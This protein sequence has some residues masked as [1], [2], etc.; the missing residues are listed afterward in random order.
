MPYEA[1]G[2][3]ADETKK[4]SP[5]SKRLCAAFAWGFLLF[6]VAWSTGVHRFIPLLVIEHYA[7]TAGVLAVVTVLATS[8]SDS[9]LSNFLFTAANLVLAAAILHGHVW[10]WGSILLDGRIYGVEFLLPVVPSLAVEAGIAAVIFCAVWHSSSDDLKT[11]GDRLAVSGFLIM[12]ATGLVFLIAILISVLEDGN[13]RSAEARAA[14]Q[15]LTQE[16]R[17]E[18]SAGT[19]K[20]DFN[21]PSRTATCV[22]PASNAE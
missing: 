15:P 14:M 13:K 19:W 17:T 12:L 1:D 9:K 3:A 5:T 11:V 6:A 21:Q 4:G 20:C 16:Q 7:L 18:I 8:N 2:A 22:A 10:G